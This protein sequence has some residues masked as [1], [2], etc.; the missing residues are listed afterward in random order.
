LMLEW[1]TLWPTSG[2]LPVR[3]QRHDMAQ[4]SKNIGARKRRFRS[5][6]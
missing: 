1:L 2:F 5:I 6:V 3:S 4:S